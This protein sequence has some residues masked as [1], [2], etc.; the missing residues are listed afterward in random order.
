MEERDGPSTEMPE[1]SSVAGDVLKMV[2]A[3]PMEDRVPR[4]RARVERFLAM[5][6]KA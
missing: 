3:D 5:A 6:G 1:G 2:Q 4:N